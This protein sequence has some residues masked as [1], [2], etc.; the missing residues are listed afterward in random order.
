M[1]S[2]AVSID[3]E[4]IANGLSGSQI[5][6]QLFDSDYPVRSLVNSVLRQ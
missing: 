6:I 4:L 2:R 5:R 3:C 1:G